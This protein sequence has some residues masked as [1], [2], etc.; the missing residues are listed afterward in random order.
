M[1]RRSAR[2]G[3][4]KCPLCGDRVTFHR[5]AGGLLNFEC[6]ADDCGVNA[7]AHKG[8]ENEREW[9]ASIEQPATAPAAP[10]VNEP[11]P[12]A[13]APAP[14]KKSKTFSMEGL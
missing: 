7:Y 2:V 11:A 1:A 12:V 3:R 6:D 14:A 5:T 8:S 10:P 9:L 13:K 4:G